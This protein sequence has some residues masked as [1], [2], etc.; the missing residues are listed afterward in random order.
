MPRALHGG[1][2]GAA[3]ASW[4]G[5][6]PAQTTRER[7][8]RDQGTLASGDG[9]PWAPRRSGC[10]KVAGVGGAAQSPDPF[11]GAAA[12]L[13]LPQPLEGGRPGRS[14]PKSGTRTVCLGRAE[15]GRSEPAKGLTSHSTDCKGPCSACK[16]A[17]A[18]RPPSTKFGSLFCTPCPALGSLTCSRGVME[19]PPLTR[20]E[21]GCCATLGTLAGPQGA[22]GVARSTA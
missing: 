14:G 19:P 2:G 4:A 11:G 17:R 8:G 22:L 6:P 20:L 10:V 3:L 15:Q 21:L 16:G 9:T 13:R 18:P 7:Q 5:Q 1:A 12:P